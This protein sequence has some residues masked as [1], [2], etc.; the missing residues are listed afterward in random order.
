MGRATVTL[1]FSLD[2]TQEPPAI[3]QD[4]TSGEYYPYYF[5]NWKHAVHYLLWC[6]KN[7]KDPGNKSHR[8]WDN[9]YISDEDDYEFIG[10]LNEFRNEDLGVIF[11]G[12]GLDWEQGTDMLNISAWKDLKPCDG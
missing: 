7:D 9:K 5:N 12:N 10:D 4:D 8:L 2:V 11:V 3:I 6:R 1:L